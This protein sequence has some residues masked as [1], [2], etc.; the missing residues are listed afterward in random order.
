MVGTKGKSGGKRDGSGRPTLAEQFIKTV[1]AWDTAIA[2]DEPALEY[3]K[4]AKQLQ[5]RIE[6][7]YAK[8]YRELQELEAIQNSR[9]WMLAEKTE[10]AG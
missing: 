7:R 6:A 3:A 10:L 5:K 2:F 4:Q 8:I 1:E 9:E